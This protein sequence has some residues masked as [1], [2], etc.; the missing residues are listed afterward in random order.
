MDDETLNI[1]FFL[2]SGSGE[3]YIGRIIELFEDF[4]GDSWFTAQWFFRVKDT[5]SFTNTSSCEEKM[6]FCIFNI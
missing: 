5:V 2:Q 4:N 3:D 1:H 6:Y